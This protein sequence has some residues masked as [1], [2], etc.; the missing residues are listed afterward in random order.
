MRSFSRTGEANRPDSQ[1]PTLSRGGEA[2]I[3]RLVREPIASDEL[4]NQ[5]TESIQ[6]K[7]GE[8]LTKMPRITR[9]TSQ[10]DSLAEARSKLQARLGR[11][12]LAR[13]PLQIRE[14]AEDKVIDV[15]DT[16]KKIGKD[17]KVVRIS[18]EE[19]VRLEAQLRELEAVREA[20]FKTLA[21]GDPIDQ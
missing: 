6:S 10:E 21:E 9:T 14:K 11:F 1:T 18:D 15:L 19:K 4:L 13:T 17:G 20:E 12:T 7:K 16:G 3:E 5:Q 2:T 8:S